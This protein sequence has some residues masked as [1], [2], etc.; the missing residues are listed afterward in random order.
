MTRF[1]DLSRRCEMAALLDSDPSLLQNHLHCKMPQWLHRNRAELLQVRAA[2]LELA[3]W[4]QAPPSQAARTLSN[5]RFIEK[6]EREISLS[7]TALAIYRKHGWIEPAAAPV[8]PGP[9]NLEW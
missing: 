7:D 4:L 2:S 8:Q 6:L 5:T 1:A 3:A 9:L